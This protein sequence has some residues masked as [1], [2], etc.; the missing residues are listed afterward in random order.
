MKRTTLPQQPASP[1]QPP[2]QPPLPGLPLPNLPL[3][4][5]LKP[6]WPK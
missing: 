5:A 6:I 3:P 1:A 4:A 2:W